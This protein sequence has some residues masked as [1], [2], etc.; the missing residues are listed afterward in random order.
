MNPRI[1][2]LAQEIVRIA[3]QDQMDETTKIVTRLCHHTCPKDI[4]GSLGGLMAWHRNEI[5]RLQTIID[6]EKTP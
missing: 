6:K 4:Y 5:D 1:K 2:K 3:Q